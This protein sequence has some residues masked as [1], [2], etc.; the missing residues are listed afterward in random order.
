[1]TDRTEDEPRDPQTGGASGP[2]EV[3]LLPQAVEPPSAASKG[4][5]S[6]LTP[7]GSEQSSLMPVA[8]RPRLP[9][10][11][12]VVVVVVLALSGTAFALRDRLFGSAPAETSL[13]S[14]NLAVHGIENAPVGG[15]LA[16][17]L[18]EAWR[19]DD[20]AVV[21]ADPSVVMAL[22]RGPGAWRMVG[23]EAD[24]GEVR[25][26]QELDEDLIEDVWC[27]PVPWQGKAACRYNVHSY[28]SP[29]LHLFDIATGES[30]ELKAPTPGW[31]I[32]ESSVSEDA[33]Y[34]ISDDPSGGGVLEL[35]RWGS[36]D[37]PVWTTAYDSA[38]D[39]SSCLYGTGAIGT[40]WSASDDLVRYCGTVFDSGDG[41]V[42][43]T[44]DFPDGREGDCLSPTL[45]GGNRIACVMGNGSG[46]V[47]L[48]SGH[49][50][51]RF[52]VGDGYPL[53][54]SGAVLP[55]SFVVWD[56]TSGKGPKYAT[57]RQFASDPQDAKT[58]E[59]PAE[60]R[61]TLAAAWDGGDRLVLVGGSGSV[62]LVS[63]AD[64]TVL[65]ESKTGAND[66]ND[67]EGV[68]LVSVCA[69]FIDEDT[70][71]IQN[72]GSRLVDADPVSWLVD[73]TTGEVTK[74]DYVIPALGSRTLD[75][76]VATGFSGSTSTG[77][78]V[79]RLVLTARPSQ[80]VAAE[81]PDG[82]PSCPSGMELVGWTQYPDGLVLVCG[83]DEGFRVVARYKGR[84]LVPTD[85]TFTLGGWTVKCQD[86]TVLTVGLGGGLVTVDGVTQAVRGWSRATGRVGFPGMAVK[87]CPPD[88]VPLSLSTWKGGWLLVC[89]TDVKTPTWA[90]WNDDILG[91]GESKD[92]AVDAGGYC[93]DSGSVCAT[94]GQAVLNGA[95]GLTVQRPI[96]ADWF[97]GTGP[98]VSG[99]PDEPPEQ[100][101]DQTVV[102]I[103]TDLL[104]EFGSA[105]VAPGSADTVRRAVSTAPQGV[106]IQVTGYSDAVGGDEVNLPLSQQRADAVA[107]IIRAQRPDL[108]VQATGRGS[109]DPVAQETNAD[110]SDNPEGRALNRRVAIRYAG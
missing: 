79:A 48:S 9:I 38:Y 41:E 108:V 93:A 17:G 29:G 50:A 107:S 62:V 40:S 33:L 101:E 110:G 84:D 88:T 25:W 47:A 43:S 10:V 16:E 59:V 60:F 109:A 85:L 49:T 89:G 37:R 19:Y 61:T 45:F 6:H 68:K 65:W 106:T 66:P 100:Q 12:S 102:T 104:F 94:P 64:G 56:G 26:T 36:L 24:T 98:G 75:P 2:A 7:D 103:A 21:L 22:R 77:G 1:M 58:V 76:V 14:S 63:T 71:W 80:A 55:D 8:R 57:L 35:S 54:L 105:E 3:S 82:F 27:N 99:D 91:D 92:V 53:A 15:G 73:A 30:S 90:A 31:E 4:Y 97:T 46:T 72:G 23:L 83:S 95:G 96:G 11:V 51:K 67:S 32:V 5:A 70:I 52:F 69:D 13:A 86:G 42:L 34:T 44:S 39:S 87:A 81:V 18:R 78:Y 20:A 28:W 74:I